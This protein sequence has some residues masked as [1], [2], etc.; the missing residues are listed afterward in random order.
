MPLWY[1][2]TTYQQIITI[3]NVS[4]PTISVS[5]R[6]EQHRIYFQKK[7][8]PENYKIRLS[9]FP[10]IEDWKYYISYKLISVIETEINLALKIKK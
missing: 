5:I 2:Q 1:A 8:I 9:C 6:I 3:Y 4:F 7:L 10:E